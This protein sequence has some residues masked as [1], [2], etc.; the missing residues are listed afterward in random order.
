MALMDAGA[1][2]DAGAEMGRSRS[3]AREGGVVLLF[4]LLSVIMTWPL[5]AHLG[6][7][8][9]GPPGDNLEYLWKMWW[10]KHS[11]LDLG[12]SPFFNPD[13]FYPVGYP[14]ALSETTMAHTLL[15]LPLT[16]LW[17]EVVAYNVV[18]L[19]TFVLSGYGL[20][21][22]LVELGARPLAG[23]IGGAAFAFSPYRLSHLGAGHLP[24]LGTGWIP[25]L[26]L[27][28]ER[29][30]RRPSWRR[31]LPV[32]LFYA[33]TA[34]SSW[35]YAL[36][37]GLF[38]ALFLLIRAR[39]WRAYL[40]M[41]PFGQGALSAL[42][43]AGVLVAPAAA[44]MVRL[45]AGGEARYDYSL[46]YI[47]QWSAS[48]LDLVYP[49][50]MHSWW[51]APLTRAYDQN[52]HENLLYLGLIALAL[53]LVGLRAWRA[54][55][56]VRAVAV[57]GAVALVLAWGTTLHLGGAP[58][59]IRVPEAVEE[60]FARG[61]ITLTGRLALNKVRFSPL[62]QPGAIVL[63]MPG[64]LLYLFVPLMDAMRVWARFGLL[65]MFAVALL[66]G[67]GADAIMARFAPG[68]PSARS[69][70]IGLALLALVLVDFAVLPYPYGYT[71]VA[72]QPVDA[73]LAEEA[74][75]RPDERLP[76]IQMPLSKTWYGWALYPNRIH[77]QPLAYGYGTF[78]PGAYREAMA[79]LALGAPDAPSDEAV[80]LLRDWGVRYVLVGAHSY[81]EHWPAVRERLDAL[82][83]L[84][85]VAVFEDRPRFYGDRLLHLVPPS[86]AVPVTEVV[87]GPLRAH[88]HDE[89]HVYALR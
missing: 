64:L 48:P 25:L 5:V 38:A 77:G 30:V 27:A 8:V 60:A 31:G 47:D 28:L 70:M 59:Y 79:E 58:V 16:A 87:Y 84:E 12:V 2:A 42:A 7:A 22:L 24:L 21:R 53:A 20:Y 1:G 39:P 89:I 11:L 52:I 71:E 54:V 36:M 73:W 81:G 37:V 45:Y 62:R 44:P 80:A 85:P 43:V 78:V 68:A 49:N 26:F 76:I 4:A 32:G 50:A 19:F 14:L 35:Y 9:L 51:G 18:V 82:S 23:I 34:L 88:L 65:T 75:S 10:F 56:L 69:A 46:A 33:L 61:M 15:G 63:P 74:R 72:A 57:L 6:R 13:I 83:D 17:G 86:A 55:P 41:R 3:L 66:A 67:L 29:L 40:R